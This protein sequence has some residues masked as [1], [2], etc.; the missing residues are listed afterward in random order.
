MSSLV[1]SISRGR[2][3]GE[4][5]SSPVEP[6]FAQKPS[7]EQSQQAEPPTE[8][9]ANEPGQERKGREATAV[10]GEKEPE[11]EG[12]RQEVGL[13]KTG[14]ERGDGPDVKGKAPPDLECTEVL[15]EDDW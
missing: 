1:G 9:Q 14:D 12:D 2:G 6:V 15:E 13:K 11:L 4:E 3:D 10:K 7:D 5:S 8:S